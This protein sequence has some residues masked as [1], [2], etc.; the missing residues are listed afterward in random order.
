MQLNSI[1]SAS[2]SAP[3]TSE[4][5]TVTP[6]KDIIGYDAFLQLLVAQLKNQDPTK[7]VDSTQYVAQLATLSDLEQSV[8]Q[9]AALEQAAAQ[10][11]VAQASAVIG[12]LATSADA[13]VSGVIASARIETDGVVGVFADG[14]EL[15]LGT[16]V[17][18][19]NA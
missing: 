12:L 5:G 18:F 13:S 3:S 14:S 6:K 9:T 11:N 10:S 4:K 19:S 16:G 2:T 8:K 15:K 1:L 17:R 7:P